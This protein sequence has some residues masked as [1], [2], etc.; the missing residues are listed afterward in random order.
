MQ[1]APL[2]LVT[3]S[4]CHQLHEPHPPTDAAHPLCARCT[5]VARRPQRFGSRPLER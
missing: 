2:V 3:C 4:I 1:T 5:P